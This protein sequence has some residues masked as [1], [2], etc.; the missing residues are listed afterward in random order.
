MKKIEVESA[1]ASTERPSFLAGYRTLLRR[2]RADYSDPSGH[3]ELARFLIE[4]DRIGRAFSSLRVA[5]ALQ[6]RRVETLDLI[7]WVHQKE[8]NLSEAKHTYRQILAVEP[9]HVQAHF[10]LGCILEQEGADDEASKCFRKVASLDPQHVEAHWK[11]ARL[12]RKQADHP[13]A[14]KY[15]QALKDLDAGNFLVPHEMGLC[16]HALGVPDKAILFLQAALRSQPDHLPSQLVLANI[17]LDGK[18]H[19]QAQELLD[20]VLA[21]H[22][23]VPEAYLLLSRLH[24]ATAKTPQALADL[25]QFQ[26]IFPLDPR[27]CFEMGRLYCLQGDFELA[28]R[29][30]SRALE[31]APENLEIHSELARVYEQL[32]AKD[33]AIR[34]AL[35][36]CERFAAEPASFARLADVYE[37]F[38]MI[39]EAVEAATRA[40]ALAPR[41]A[42]LFCKRARLQIQAG[43]YN[44]AVLDF[45][46][47]R[48]LDP[49]CPDARLDA[50]LIRGHKAVRKA[51]D[52]FSRGREAADRGDFQQA[53]TLYR[54][55]LSLVPD[56]VGW[57][58]DMLDVFV[59]L[60]QFRDAARVLDGIERLTPDDPA[61]KRRAALFHYQMGAYE[62]AFR[63]FEQTVGLDGSDVTSRIHVI[64][65]LGHRFLDQGVPPDRYP[66]LLAAYQD[67]LGRAKDPDLA[68]L[69]LAYFYL[70]VGRHVARGPDWRSQARENL[71][72]VGDRSTHQVTVWKLRGLHEL[73]LLGGDDAARLPLVRRLAETAPAEPLHVISYLEALLEQSTLPAEEYERAARLAEPHSASGYVRALRLRL[74]WRDA[75]RSEGRRQAARKET[76]RLQRCVSEE[77]EGFL[78]FLDLGLALRYL[79]IESEWLQGARKSDIAFGKAASLDPA[80]P[81]PWWGL[82]KNAGGAPGAEAQPDRARMSAIAFKALR[83]HSMEPLLHLEAG[84]AFITG[85]DPQETETGLRELTCASV[86]NTELAPAQ[87][88]LA[89]HYRRLGQT[90]AAHHHYLRALECLAGAHHAALAR[91]ELSR[92]V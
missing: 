48:E 68:R 79:T 18:A 50:E 29:E 47:A 55:V 26:K 67:N 88:A 56:N 23:R 82:L 62:I 35:L 21:K 63:L 4:H 10:Q 90:P 39:P 36:R 54:Q 3:L 28:E 59:S 87:L 58:R 74:W 45:Q 85:P 70:S 6:P 17:Y 22:P 13:K 11:L 44:E 80:S 66:A 24:Q 37:R 5:R 83:R 20:S 64:R 31:M 81:W 25:L 2:V 30:L 52:L 84:L 32:G 34:L 19:P 65:A 57:L 71:E 89:R 41:E 69:E 12:S 75:A 53:L 40:I 46:T 92:L 8:G 43:N 51:F 16:Y 76:R 15:L 9:D 1:G 42:D 38:E 7:G 72:L 73:E 78:G 14:L 49:A 27:G 60:G 77:P 91:D 86:L 61:L 33:K